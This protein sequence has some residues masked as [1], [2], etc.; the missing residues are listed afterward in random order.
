MNR[1]TDIARNLFRFRIP[2][3]YKTIIRKE[4][5]EKKIN[6]ETTYVKESPDHL[7]LATE[8]NT[9]VYGF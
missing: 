6:K 9:K 1:Q 2:V 4:L 3:Q 5:D 7:K 8:I